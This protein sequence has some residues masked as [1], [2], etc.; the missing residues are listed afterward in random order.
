MRRTALLTALATAAVAL[1]PIALGGD[2]ARAG[3]CGG[4]ATGQA[5][6][7]YGPVSESHCGF[8]GSNPG[9][10]VYYNWHVGPAGG[11]ACVDG[12]GFDAAHPKGTW[13]SLG[14]GERSIDYGKV[15]GVPWGNVLATPKVRV[16]SQ[17]SLR[18]VG[19][20]WS[21]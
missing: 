7:H 14:C 9:S 6:H 16:F 3:G 11:K 17:D 2:E 21:H 5:F 20:D 15:E 1:A 10:R 12:W 13:F 8:A 4:K 19:V 18:G